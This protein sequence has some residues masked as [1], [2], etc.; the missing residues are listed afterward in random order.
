MATWQNILNQNKATDPFT[1]YA[2]TYAKKVSDPNYRAYSEADLKDMF[3]TEKRGLYQDVFDPLER[4]EASRMANQGIGG[5]GVA[6]IRWEDKVTNPEKRI[7]A[8]TYSN[9]QNLNREA[10]RADQSQLLGMTP[11][12]TS[13]YYTPQELWLQ[14]YGIDTNLEASKYGADAQA[15]AAKSQAKGGIIG[16]LLGL[17]SK[18]I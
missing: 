9:I 4:R 7:L 16:G 3:E 14:K 10:T 17:A 15:R 2:E 11:A 5:S 1:S 8:D 13:S 12:L 18:F 6:K